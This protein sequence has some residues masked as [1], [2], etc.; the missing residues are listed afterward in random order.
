MNM[1]LSSQDII[2]E[3]DIKD[4]NSN[5]KKFSLPEYTE[6]VYDKIKSALNIDK[7][8]YNVYLIDNFTKNKLN[9]IKE[10]ISEVLKNKD[11][12]KDICYVVKEDV[13]KP[14]ALFLSNGKGKILKETVEELQ[15]VY[16]KTVYDFYNSSVCKE[17]EE[18]IENIQNK[19]SELVAELMNNARA[20]GFE[21]RSTSKGFTFI[22]LKGEEVMTEREYDELE[23]EKKE[24][25]LKSVSELKNKSQQILEEL[26]EIESNELVKVRK[27]LK[28]YLKEGTKDIKNECEEEFKN[29]IEAIEF[30]KEINDEIEINIVDNYSMIYEDDEEKINE[31]IMKYDVNVLVDN[32]N[33]S[34]PRVIFEENPSITN[35][36]GCIEYKNENGTYVTDVSFIKSGSI[37]KANEGCL[38]VRAN[39]LLTNTNAYYNLKKTITSEKVD[40]DYSKGYIDILSLRGLDPEPI[41]FKEKVIIIGDYQTYDLLYNYDEDFG[42]IFKIKAQYS[43]VVEVNDDTK[44]SL[45]DSVQ[46]I[47][48]DNKLKP[49]DKKTIREIAKYLSRRAEHRKKMFFNDEELSK[50]LML[51]NNNVLR[52]NRDTIT[53]KDI[54]DIAYKEDLV[55]KEIREVY[56]EG[57]ILIKVKDK[58]IGQINGLSVIDSGYFS[59]G[60]PI[61]ITCSCYRGEGEIIDVQKQSDLSGNI[62][63]KAVNILK[64]IISERFGKYNKLPVNF[65]LSFEQIYGKID[66]DSASVAE[67]VCMIS[68]LSGIPI[69]QNI[70]V[71]GSINQFG[72]V[73]PIGGVNEKIEGFFKIC[74]VI[75][76][77]EDKGVLIPYS[78]RNNIVLSNEVE[79][80]IEE[81]RFHIYTMNNIQDAVRTLMG[82]YKTVIAAVKKEIRKYGKK[83]I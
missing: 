55:E 66:G 31:I 12:P 9:D 47:C 65:H 44:L 17:K 60:K 1:E 23:S 34:S 32:S 40:F 81:G 6:E 27:I 29:D 42:K 78:N 26:K 82:D 52:E 10:F 33:H 53:A 77:I 21:I 11:K 57:K 18:I 24:E 79:K 75:D 46:K 28:E 69:K 83:T 39:S 62:H 30:L 5:K 2:Y 19:R 59:F 63:S 54:I 36:L 51:S 20:Q 37:L 41:K 43:P 58:K 50:I 71:T 68:A 64:G 15:D 45:M 74:K 3:F 8:G 72:E 22:P 56:K 80:A 35:L 49:L 7:E 73:Q 16:N 48:N 14:F 38:I 70:S 4:I 25:I 13:D 67:L 76:N 61:R